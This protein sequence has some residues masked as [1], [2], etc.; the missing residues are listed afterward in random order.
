MRIDKPG[1]ESDAKSNVLS[2]WTALV[3]DYFPGCSGFHR[4]KSGL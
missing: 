2:L 3:W 4:W 1:V